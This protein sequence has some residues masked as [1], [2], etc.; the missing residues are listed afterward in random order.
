[1]PQPTLV[2]LAINSLCFFSTYSLCIKFEE[3]ESR[4]DFGVDEIFL[5]SLLEWGP[6]CPSIKA[7]F[8]Q[9]QL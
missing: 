1:M 9:A 8:V 3:S 4:E 6:M 5:L 2:Q 7:R